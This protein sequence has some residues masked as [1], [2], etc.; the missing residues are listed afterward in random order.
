MFKSFTDNASPATSAEVLR[1]VP[2]STSQELRSDTELQ[3]DPALQARLELK[4]SL[5]DRLLAQMNLAVIDKVEVPELRREVANLVME[6]LKQEKTPLHAEAFNELV[7]EL[8]NELMGLGPLEPLLEDPTVNDILVNSFQKVY[9]ERHGV[10]ERSTV[11]FRDERH[12]LRIIDKIVSR[13]GRRVDESQPWVDARLEDG[14]RVNVII[15]PCAIDGPSLS[16]RKFARKPLTLDRL[17]ETGALTQGASHVLQAF[18]D[19]R[20]NVLISGG[21]GSGKTTMLNAMSA[22]ID[23]RQRVVTIED[24]AELQLQQ[25]HVVRL[26]TRPANAEG[27]GAVTQRDLVRNALRMRP[28]RIIVGEVRGAEAFDMLQAMNTGHDGSMTT[29]HANSS[30]DALG[31]LEQMVS[32]AGFDFPL[33]AVR[34]QI[35][36]GIQIVLQLSRLSDGRRR[37]VSISEVTGM[38]GDVITMQEIFVF[39]KRGRGADGAVLGDFVATGIRPKCAE[40]LLA[41]GIELRADSFLEPGGT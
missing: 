24:A 30:R 26:E 21:T 29:I 36:A 38:E 40:L 23:R 16:I 20:L 1:M 31:R 8:L 2:K 12:L 37:I 15:R 34:Q 11:R 35:A 13:V 25:D 17:V 19:A 18:V 7:D 22:F 4:S 6:H 41:A 28:D 10:L 14:S 39:R 3:E 32:M 27:G 9:V 33:R 5:H